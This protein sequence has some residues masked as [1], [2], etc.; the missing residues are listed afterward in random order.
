MFP[1]KVVVRVFFFVLFFV[2]I[3]AGQ[4]T[5]HGTRGRVQGAAREQGANWH[6]LTLGVNTVALSFGGHVF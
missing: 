1:R 4:N 2:A 3:T 5:A 6:H